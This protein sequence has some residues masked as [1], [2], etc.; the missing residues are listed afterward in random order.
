[1]RPCEDPRVAAEALREL[2]EAC[3]RALVAGARG[4]GSRQQVRAAARRFV[5][6]HR[7]DAGHL[8]WVLR[9]TTASS[10]LAVA[11][12]G[13]WPARAVAALAPFGPPPSNPVAGLNAGSDSAPALADLD[14][15]G[16]RDVVAGIADGTFVYYANTGDAGAPAF[17]TAANPLAGADVGVSAVPALGDLDGDGD[18]DL[19]AG[20]GSGG[21]AYFKNTGTIRSPAFTSSGVTNPLSGVSIGSNAAPALGDVDGDGD[22]D[23]VAGDGA[24]L[25][26]LFENTG[27]AMTAAFVERTGAANPLNGQDVGANA[28]PALGDL[29]GDGDLDLIAGES[30]GGFFAFENTGN[31]TSPHFAART[32]TANPLFGQNVGSKSAA[33]LGD[34]D[35]DGDA[36]LVAGQQDGAFTSLTNRAGRFTPRLGA[37]NPLDTQDVGA[38]STAA[39]GDLDADGLLDL[40]TGNSNGTFNY[41]ENTGTP[42]HPVFV[43]RTGAGN[44]LNG[45]DAG[46]GAAP[47]LGDLDG[48][49]DLDLVSGELLGGFV[50][51]ENTGTPAS[52]AFVER[53]GSQNP[54]NLLDVGDESGPALGDLDGDGDLDLLVGN[55]N[56]LFTYFEN[57]GSPASPAFATGGSDPIGNVALGEGYA[58]L[59]L[60][61]VDAD[62]DLDL[63]V[64]GYTFH[65]FENTGGPTGAAFVRRTGAANPLASLIA[66]PPPYIFPAPALGDLDGDGDLDLVSGKSDGTFAYYERLHPDRPVVSER[67]G[68]A[69]PLFGQDVGVLAGPALVDLDAD[70]DA[71]LVAG[72]D[73]GAFR[74]FENTGDAVH[75]LYLERTGGANPL[76]GRDVGDEARPTFGDLDGDGDFDLLAGNGAGGFSYY[77]NTGPTTAPAF[78][79]PVANPFGLTNVGSQSA[80]PALGDLDGDGDLDLVVGRY[81]GGLAYFENTGNA[82]SPAFAPRTGAANPFDGLAL[83]YYT[84]PTI[85]DFDGDGDLDLVVGGAFG[86]FLYLQNDGSVTDPDFM[87]RTG[88]KSPLDAVDVGDRAAPAA[89]DLDGD[90][91]ADLV[92]GS[93]AGTFAVHYFPEPARGSLLGAGAALV[94]WLA[95]RRP[96][97]RR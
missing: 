97:E 81:Y 3:E 8:A 62:G 95:R 57:V 4:A 48:D 19:V 33:A 36:D 29:D 15:D 67:T 26:H 87:R 5:R 65:Y 51:Y 59:A 85:G 32:G 83:A 53:T 20:N 21:F 40:V 60:G 77:Q 79:A 34:L 73:L 74:F 25:I 89:A 70:G 86:R 23:L 17:T 35:G 27:D 58:K 42:T 2:A 71:D 1:M 45:L 10:A 66:P 76:T 30:A 84:S 82:T 13:L 63:V 96:R 11:L 47:T 75:A 92:T 41:F 7:R 55:K 43:P 37:A 78:G 56:G 22:L 12:L 80:S 88:A 46:S 38:R 90:G 54:L 68:S 52:P 72:E 18:L 91:D 28:V 14:A 39:L 16:D 61:D 24:G 49:G 64:G 93:L 6:R 94:R 50:Y 69:N 9:T 44:P 31:A